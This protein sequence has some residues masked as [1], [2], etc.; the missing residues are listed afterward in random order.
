MIDVENLQLVQKFE[1][2]RKMLDR[3]YEVLPLGEQVRD[4]S[5]ATLAEGAGLHPQRGA[6]YVSVFI[7]LGIVERVGPEYGTPTNGMSAGR[8]YHYTLLLSHEE[9]VERFEKWATMAAATDAQN[10]KD[11]ANRRY[12]DQ[13][14]AEAG[15]DKPA[16]LAASVDAKTVKR[17]KESRKD[18]AS[19][20]VEAARQYANRDDR[21]DGMIAD[22]EKAAKEMGI[23]FDAASALGLFTVEHDERLEVIAQVMPYIE[24]LEREN[25]R[26]KSALVQ[27]QNEAATAAGRIPINQG[28]NTSSTAAT[29]TY[30]VSGRH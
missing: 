1:S 9:A 6:P 8:H 2:M 20:L 19:A 25:E 11:G 18:E 3:M 27:A 28:T 26:L 16:G 10:R 30:D 7:D 14:V 24:R 21:L 23:A 15:E 29:I 17:L 12:E 13:L 22:M 5:A 4:V